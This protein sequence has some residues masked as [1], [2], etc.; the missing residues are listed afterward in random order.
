MPKVLR[1]PPG[2]VDH[3]GGGI[4]DAFPVELEVLRIL[5]PV[6]IDDAVTGVRQQGEVDR[7]LAV[8]R[9]LVAEAPALLASIDADGQQADLLVGFEQGSELGKLP[10][11]VRSPVAAVED[12]HHR[13]LFPLCGQGD[14]APILI[15]EREF[16]RPVAG[17]H[18][19]AALRDSGRLRIGGVQGWRSQ[20]AYD[21]YQN[22]RYRVKHGIHL[23]PDAQRN[24]AFWNDCSRMSKK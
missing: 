24:D 7:P 18:R 12:Q 15:F 4:R 17:A 2:L 5:Q 20:R 19:G 16:G 1:D 8:G 14:R 10:S 21:Q 9:D 11:A 3:V 23:Q 22:D 6:E 13:P